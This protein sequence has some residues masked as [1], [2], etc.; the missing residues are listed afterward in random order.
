M[1]V[2]I[3]LITALQAFA[4]TAAVSQ[5][6]DYNYVCT[7]ITKPEALVFKTSSPQKIWRTT[8]NEKGQIKTGKAFQLSDIKINAEAINKEGQVA[9]FKARLAKNYELKG[10]FAKDTDGDLPLTV[11]SSYIPDGK[12]SQIKDRYNC[13]IEKSDIVFKLGSLNE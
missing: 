2:L 9:S 8:L 10:L 3:I 4:A 13:S 7:H 12:L 6:K 5:I 11:V 1:K